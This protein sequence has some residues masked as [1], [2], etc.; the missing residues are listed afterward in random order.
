MLFAALRAWLAAAFAALAADCAA[1][2]VPLAV[3]AVEFAELAALTA[4]AE[5]WT[6]VLARPSAL[7]ATFSGLA[8]N[9]GITQLTAKT[10][11][12]ITTRA[13]FVVSIARSRSR[14]SRSLVAPQVRIM[15]RAALVG[16]K[17]P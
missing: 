1:A 15:R 14:M 8:P 4:R 17:Q 11:P 5:S 12:T 6:A 16:T 7:I 9:E 10:A 3:L 2:A 13:L